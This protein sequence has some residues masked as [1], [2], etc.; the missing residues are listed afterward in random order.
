MDAILHLEAMIKLLKSGMQRLKSVLLLLEVIV[1]V[2]CLLHLI[3]M[4]GRL[5]LQVEM[6]QLKFGILSK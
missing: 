6:I 2:Y 4:V 5:Y 3:N 1:N